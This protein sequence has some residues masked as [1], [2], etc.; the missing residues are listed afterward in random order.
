[1]KNKTPRAYPETFFVKMFTKGIILLVMFV[2][3]VSA[4]P[5]TFN[6]HGRLLDSDEL[7]LT[8][9]YAMNFSLY[10]VTTG[11]SA[12]WTDNLS[13]VTDVEGIY[14]VILEDIDLDFSQQYYLGISVEGDAEMTPRMNLTSNPYVFRVNV[15][16]YLIL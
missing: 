12:L 3:F 14:N 2:G 9:T 7:P 16:D 1:M 13:V 10:S 5:Q 6:I 15:S 11:G 4:I 8:G